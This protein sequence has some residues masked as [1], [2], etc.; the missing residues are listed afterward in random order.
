M[1]KA[2]IVIKNGNEI[3]DQY[4]FSGD[5]KGKLLLC[6]TNWFLGYLRG[7]LDAQPMTLQMPCVMSI[8]GYQAWSNSGNYTIKLVNAEGEIITN[9][10][11]II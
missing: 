3:V 4:Y 10:D 9:I 11:S 1:Y 6:A 2:Q 8:D 7:K 5:D